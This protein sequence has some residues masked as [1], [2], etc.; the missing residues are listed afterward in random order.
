[1][2]G[3]G[4]LDVELCLHFAFISDLKCYFEVVGLG[5]D[6]VFIGDQFYLQLVGADVF[7]DS[8]LLFENSLIV[9]G[10]WRLPDILLL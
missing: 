5:L 9:S 4:L 1:M 10:G 7:E 2:L 8:L 3:I 6:Q